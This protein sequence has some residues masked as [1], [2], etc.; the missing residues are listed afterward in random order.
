LLPKLAQK[1]QSQIRLRNPETTAA[2]QGGAK[3]PFGCTEAAQRLRLEFHIYLILL[4]FSRLARI[5]L[6]TRLTANWL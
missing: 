1:G 4:F 5:L 3:S 6:C 2:H